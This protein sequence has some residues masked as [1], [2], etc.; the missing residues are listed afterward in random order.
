MDGLG[1]E[2]DPGHQPGLSEWGRLDQSTGYL[3]YEVRVGWP[4]PTLDNSSRAIIA[5][6]L[7]SG[8]FM[9]RIGESSQGSPDAKIG[10]LRGLGKSPV[11]R[12][13]YRSQMFWFVSKHSIPQSA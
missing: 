9:R 3:G 11:N 13:F 5:N 8:K 1:Y 7:Y 2:H 6:C 10:D 12:G 4:T